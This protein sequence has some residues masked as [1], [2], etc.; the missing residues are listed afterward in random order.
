MNKLISF[1]IK[2]DEFRLISRINP[3][4]RRMA[5]FLG[6]Y[7]NRDMSYSQLLLFNSLMIIS[8]QIKRCLVKKLDAN[9]K[10]GNQ[11]KDRLNKE[12]SNIFDILN[13]EIS[14]DK[15]SITFDI[16][17]TRQQIEEI[18]M[19]LERIEA[20]LNYFIFENE[21]KKAAEIDVDKRSR[22]AILLIQIDDDLIK[23]INQYKGVIKKRVEDN[24]EELKTYFKVELTEEERPVIFKPILME[25]GP[26]HKCLNGHPFPIGS[27]CLECNTAENWDNKLN[28]FVQ[29]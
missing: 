14:I 20:I 1:Y 8:L 7:K 2:K 4:M 3:R 11:Q 16:F 18:L 22:I 6:L 21:A 5:D 12:I 23:N 26:W 17:L 15:P 13:K 29:G 28:H 25:K 9:R 27:K 19:Q 10:S 24:F